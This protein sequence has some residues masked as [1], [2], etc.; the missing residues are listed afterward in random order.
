MTNHASLSN[1]RRIFLSST[2]TRIFLPW[3][4]SSSEWGNQFGNGIDRYIAVG[5]GTGSRRW[6]SISSMLYPFIDLVRFLRCELR[7]LLSPA[8]RTLSTQLPTVR[9]RAVEIHTE[10]AQLLPTLH[11]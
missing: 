10:E 6:L 3:R 11:P 2:E 4:S 8:L 1:R 7:V 5:Q 9:A